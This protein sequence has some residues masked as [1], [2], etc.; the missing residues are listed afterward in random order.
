MQLRRLKEEDRSLL[1]KR[2]YAEPEDEQLGFLNKIIGRMGR[3]AVVVCVR[4]WWR[5]VVGRPEGRYAA[6]PR[7]V[8]ATHGSSC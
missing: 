4:V 5:G 6:R 2:V 7:P 8:C 1:L 3:W